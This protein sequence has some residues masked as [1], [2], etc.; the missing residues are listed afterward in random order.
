[1]RTYTHDFG[2]GEVLSMFSG[3]KGSPVDSAW[4][5]NTRNRGLDSSSRMSQSTRLL[6]VSLGVNFLPE[7]SL[8]RKIHAKGLLTKS[9]FKET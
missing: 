2:N 3:R 1:M 7:C 5:E 8:L 4:G 6:S 9:S